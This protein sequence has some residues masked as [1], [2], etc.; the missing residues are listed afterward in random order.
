MAMADDLLGQAM[1]LARRGASRPK[2]ADLRRAISSAYYAVFHLLVQDAAR[3]MSPASPAGLP[4]Q[5]S[6]VFSHGEM[7]PACNSILNTPSATLTAL[8]P[9]GFSPELRFIAREFVGL[10]GLRHEADYDLTQSYTRFDVLNL[11]ARVQAVFGMWQQIRQREETN[12]F[13]AALLLNRL[14]GR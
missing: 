6:R 13:C 3:R 7:K 9:E 2:Q 11:L 1:H 10:Q 5:I 8:Q 14:W 12:V 4:L